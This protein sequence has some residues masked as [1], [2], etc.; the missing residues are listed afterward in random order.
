MLEWD[1]DTSTGGELKMKTNRPVMKRPCN[2]YLYVHER[3]Y[4][5]WMLILRSPGKWKKLNEKEKEAVRGYSK[6][7]FVATQ[8][9]RTH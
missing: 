7:G 4:E 1:S 5:L 3:A 9:Y 8:L 6:N 2:R